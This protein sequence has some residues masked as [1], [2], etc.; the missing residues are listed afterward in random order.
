[1]K[2]VE[3][4]FKRSI[5][6]GIHDLKDRL[7]FVFL[8]LVIFRMGSFIPIPGIDIY[9]IT[10]IFNKKR[11]S[12]VIEILN[13]FSGGAFGRTSIFAL[14]I[15][16]YISSSIIVQLLTVI[17]P[18]LSEIKKEGEVGRQTINRYIRYGTLILSFIQSVGI[19]FGIKN[20]IGSKGLIM[21]GDLHFYLTSI[22][23]LMTGTIF[24]MWLGEKINERGIGNGVSMI[25]F[26]SII[27]ELPSSIINTI[28]QFRQGS[29]NTLMFSLILLFILCITGFVTFMERSQR[30]ILVNY[31]RH[32]YRRRIYSAQSTHLPLKIN[33]ASVI[34]AIFASSIMLLPS[35][36]LTWIKKQQSNQ[37]RFFLNFV[38]ENFH[39]GK[40]IYMLCYSS[41]VIFFCFFYTSLLFNPSET[42]DS[43]KKSGAFLP[44]IRPGKQTAR[45]IE[46]IMNKLTFI[47]SIYISFICL[48]PELM[49]GLIKVPFYFGGTSLL[50]VV[51]VIIDFISQIQ[52]ILMTNRYQNILKA[53]KF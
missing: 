35:A 11:E 7:V 21:V 1:M 12:A 19:S 25:I 39:P 52:T 8:S 3:I 23:S 9:S 37:S 31:S 53:S 15:M 47:G 46:K 17:H 30:K 18:K 33:M 40:P 16:P 5:N 26:V 22:V 6:R 13:M 41:I 43:L 14:G 20:S 28:E 38:F 45:Y 49:R 27:S 29:I 2:K 42:A 36:I 48:V 34:P 50:I 10:K 44:G 4:N 51:V 32:Q 24:L